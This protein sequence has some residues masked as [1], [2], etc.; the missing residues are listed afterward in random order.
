MFIGALLLVLG[1]IMLLDRM[2]IIEGGIW[3]YFWPIAVIAL[4]I[5]MIYRGRSG[6]RKEP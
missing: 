6:S 1:T 5:S 4:G 2:G 3:D